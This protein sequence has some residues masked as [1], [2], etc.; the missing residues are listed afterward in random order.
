MVLLCV[1][2]YTDNIMRLRTKQKGSLFLAVFADWTEAETVER[3]GSVL[4]DGLQM[5]LGAISFV[6]VEAIIGMEQMEVVHQAVAVYL[7]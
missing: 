7:G 5:M 4:T 1:Y 2:F 6:A 3:A